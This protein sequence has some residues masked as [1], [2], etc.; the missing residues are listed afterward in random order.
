MTDIYRLKTG[1]FITIAKSQISTFLTTILQRLK[2]HYPSDNAIRLSN[3]PP[4]YF[5]LIN[6]IYINFYTCR[7]GDEIKNEFAVGFET[8]A[9]WLGVLG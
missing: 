1:V 8:L 6:Q 7:I 5:K 4:L 2:N 3:N 9:R